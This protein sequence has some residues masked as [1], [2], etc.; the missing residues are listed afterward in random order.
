MKK[1]LLITLVLLSLFSCEM[2]Q[3]ELEKA[4][5][6]RKSAL[7]VCDCN[8]V[9]VNTNT[10]NGVKKVTVVVSESSSKDLT[11]KAEEIMTQIENDYP[12]IKENQEI[13]IQFENGP[14][15]EEYGF[16]GNEISMKVKELDSEVVSLSHIV[17]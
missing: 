14:I 5:S 7:K 2:M 3:K 16:E 6:I 9:S 11:S 17:Q 8:S 15:T 10:S 4:N 13:I 12:K 1:P